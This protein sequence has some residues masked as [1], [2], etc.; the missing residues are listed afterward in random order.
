MKSNGQTSSSEAIVPRT[1]SVMTYIEMGSD[2]NNFGW[3][4]TDFAAPPSTLLS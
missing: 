2:G 4:V 1:L 3:T